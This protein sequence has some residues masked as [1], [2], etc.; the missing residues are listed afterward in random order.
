MNRTKP[1]GTTDRPERAGAAA[2]PICRRLFDFERAADF[3]GVPVGEIC[4]RIRS[5][6]LKVYHLGDGQARVDEA[7]LI[8]NIP[9]QDLEW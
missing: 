1:A 6:E 4:R 9:P 2:K 3:S 7:D 5:G 8:A